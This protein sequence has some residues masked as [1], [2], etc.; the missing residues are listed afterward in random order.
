MVSLRVSTYRWNCNV[1]LL[2]VCFIY[3][4]SQEKEENFELQVTGLAMSAS[5]S[6]LG[7]NSFKCKE[8]VDKDVL[9][10]LIFI[11]IIRRIMRRLRLTFLTHPIKSNTLSEVI[12]LHRII[13]TKIGI[14]L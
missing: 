4:D 13:E 2:D 8:R 6:N 5:Y 11:F 3:Q 10:D 9:A 12:C 14:N 1:L 7:E